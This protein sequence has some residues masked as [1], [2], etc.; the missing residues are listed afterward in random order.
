M[1]L[2]KT[3]KT[4]N[5]IND[6]FVLIVPA[7]FYVSCTKEDFSSGQENQFEK[8]RVIKLGQKI[9][10]PY[11]LENMQQAYNNLYGDLL[12]TE[13]QATHKYVRFLP[14]NE[15]ELDILKND[16]S[17]VLYDYP[18]DYEISEGEGAYHD[19]NL[20]DSCITWQYTVVPYDYEFPNITNELLYEVFI[21]EKA[22]EELKNCNLYD[23]EEE[24]FR[25][26]GNVDT[27]NGNQLKAS[28]WHPSGNISVWDDVFKQ[29]IPLEGAKVQ[30]RWST[31]IKTC[32]TDANGDFYQEHG[33][34]YKVNY[35]IKWESNDYDIRDGLSGQA[36]YNGPKQKCSWDLEIKGG[37]SL[38]F[39]TIHRAAYKFYYGENL[40][41]KRFNG[42]QR[43]K[44]CY[45]DKEGDDCVGKTMSLGN[46]VPW[47]NDI[48]IFGKT[49]YNL[50]GSHK[51][52]Y[53]HE[54]IKT[55]MHEIGHRSHL[56]VIGYLKYQTV[57]RF[58]DESWAEA[59]SWALLND[60]YRRMAIKINR[61]DF[62]NYTSN[63]YNDTGWSSSWKENWGDF[64]F[65]SPIFIDLIDDVNQRYYNINDKGV[66][67][68]TESNRADV[69]NDNVTGFTLKYIQ[70]NI[71]PT[72][73]GLSSLKESIRK[74]KIAGISDSDL[75]GLLSCY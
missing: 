68:R 57:H 11:R 14:Q 42:G 20:P 40:G 73:F 15:D 64:Y 9:D 23:I 17:I 19:K 65:Y 56:K 26:T 55:T 67:S 46:I 75:E 44:F 45:K 39:A 69:P 30:T 49:N 59:V 66:K 48:N 13:L 16:T 34:L 27:E 10:D 51:D 1:K 4:K 53:T 3:V 18:L 37:K 12:K 70:D 33:F 52:R 31:N 21:P 28:R 38:Y 5:L 50:T 29:C 47:I 63:L 36:W 54:I 72:S 43:E 58:V 62:Q 8:N 2:K 24:S 60:E 71:L 74:N 6:L 35:A 25:L 61:W 32:K 22:N 41:L 7:I